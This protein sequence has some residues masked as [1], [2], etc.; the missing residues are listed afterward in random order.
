MLCKKI[1]SSSL[2]LTYKT[3]WEK[4]KFKSRQNVTKKEEEQFDELLKKYKSIQDQLASLD[5]KE[6]KSSNNSPSPKKDQPTVDA[7]KDKI[8]D[9]ENKNESESVTEQVN[10][11]SSIE[12]KVVSDDVE[13]NLIVKEKIG[14]TTGMEV[15]I[16]TNETRSPGDKVEGDSKVEQVCTHFFMIMLILSDLFVQFHYKLYDVY[17]SHIIVMLRVFH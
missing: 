16:V 6:K 7:T 15:D 8:D 4:R 17:I 13:D 1:V 11:S 14:N 12:S 2:T 3:V 9:K 5:K 10:V